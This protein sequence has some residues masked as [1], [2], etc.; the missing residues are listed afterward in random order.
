[1]PDRCDV[2]IVGGGPAG[3]S[4]AARLWAAG[5]DVVVVDKCRFPRDKSCAGWITPPVLEHLRIDPREH[6]QGRVLQPIKGFSVCRLGG[7][8][9]ETDY[10]TV[11]SYGIRRCEFDTYL[12]HRSHARLRLG[13]PL[14]T[15]ERV[16]RAWLINGELEAPMVVGAGGHFCPVAR[17]LGARTSGDRTVVAAQETEFKLSREQARIC[18]VRPEVPELFFC[19]DL[20]GY[21]WCVRKGEYLNV[22]MGREDSTRLSD[23]LRAFVETLQS[24]NR[25][26]KDIPT[27]FQGHAYTL[28]GHAPRELLGDGL[29]LVGDAAGL[30]AAY[31]GEGIR[32]AVESGLLAAESIL[33][34]GGN[35]EREALASYLKSLIDRFGPPESSDGWIAHIPTRIKLAVAGPLFASAWFTRRI[36]LDRWFLARN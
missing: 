11:V 4:C 2:L 27:R 21:G 5:L 23:H 3:S 36:V 6:E 14:K 16:G 1:M 26:P 20:Q 34:A 29:L 28:Y 13:A 10:G 22:G 30:A 31:S 25:I 18:R 12:L 15:L 33:S 9:V 17:H 24:Q 35:Y 32:A 7:P 8:M 19:E